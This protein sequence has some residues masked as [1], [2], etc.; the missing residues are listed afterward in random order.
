MTGAALNE[1]LSRCDKVTFEWKKNCTLKDSLIKASLQAVVGAC[2]VA[3]S[4]QHSLKGKIT[5]VIGCVLLLDD[6][7]FTKD[8]ASPVC[9]AD[10][11]CQALIVRLLR[12]KLSDV[13]IVAEEDFC[14]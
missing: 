6:E 9:V 3:K 13:E 5:K 10:L 12:E 14:K 8:D 7:K 11:C 4:L 2:V 1:I